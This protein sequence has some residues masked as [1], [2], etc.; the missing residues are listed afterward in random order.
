MISR[1]RGK[2]REKGENKVIIEV[3][4]F[5]YEVLVPKAILEPMESRIGD[6]HVVEL[7]IF[8]YHQIE[9]SRSIP[10][11]VGFLNEIEKEFFEK[12]ITV[13]GIGPKAAVRALSLPIPTIAK[14]I[15]SAD[16]SLLKSLP[17]IGEQRAREIIAKLQGKV[18]KFGLL[19]ERVKKDG[20]VT[21]SAS[22]A[23]NIR[24]EAIEVLLQLEY[25]RHEAEE[26]VKK[27]TSRDCRL[28]TV[29][30]ILNE[31]YRQKRNSDG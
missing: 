1:V 7:V 10:V 6:D 2:L 29:E 5:C 9:P 23:E 8:H 13:S 31:I 20:E 19:Q 22:K 24:K 28:T 16:Y 4:N 15:D 14:A 11:M 30:D 18:G 3:N 12:F 26:M 17:G 27:T 25:T 21:E